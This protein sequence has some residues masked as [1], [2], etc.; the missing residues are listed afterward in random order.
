M[1]YGRVI[2]RQTPVLQVGRLR[3]KIDIAAPTGAQD[4]TGGFTPGDGA[5]YVNCWAS[6]EA[7]T[8][9][10]KFAAHEFVSQVS[11][12]IVI[13]YIGPAP[14]WNPTYNYITG[15]LTLDPNGNLQQA[16]NDGLSGA[17]QPTWNP[18]LGGTT[19]DG[20]P[21]TGISW[22]NL[23]T[24]FPRTGVTSQMVVWFQGRNFQIESVLNP[25]ERNKMLILL[26]IEINDSRQ[27]IINQPGGLL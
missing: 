23:G 14:Q 2:Q 25:D 22:K 7:L 1:P 13:R 19:A 9:V 16:Q 26:C 8:G 18:T 6:I 21:S 10:E 5:V 17:T 3:H 12:Q 27:Q 15:A 20:D 4:S 24:T 11:H